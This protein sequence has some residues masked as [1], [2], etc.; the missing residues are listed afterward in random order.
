[1]RH[2]GRAGTA[3]TR[4]IGT[5]LAALV[6]AG[7]LVACGSTG[8]VSST[9]PGP[10]ATASTVAGVVAAPT[11]PRTATVGPPG[12]RPDHIVVVIL[13]NKASAQIDGSPSAPYLNSL[14]TNSAVLTQ[15]RAVAHPSEPNYL[16]LFSG[17]T[18]NVTD[19]RCPLALG[20]QPNLGRQLMD[21]GLSFAGYSEGLPSVGFTGCSNGRYAAKHNPWIDFTNLPSSV[22]QP[23]SAFPSDYTK[24]PTV[25]FLIPDL[26]NDMHDCSVGTGDSWMR[27]HID[28]YARWARANNSRLVVTFDED[29]N[30]SDNRILTFVSGAAVQAGR[31]GQPVDHYGLLATIEDLYGLNRLGSAATATPIAGIW[32]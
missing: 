14:M 3:L 27:D 10:G 30:A 22:N 26:C 11:S 19:D 16:A 32:R 6:G 21:A 13:E 7:S 15:S 4:R 18:H 2:P 23:A 5:V 24:L 12:H 9:V 1:M 17:S 28:S 20:A 29:D 31:Y 8:A 25:A